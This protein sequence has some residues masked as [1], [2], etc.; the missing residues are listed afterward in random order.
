M[1]Q[2]AM[3]ADSE[4]ISWMREIR[5]HIHQ[6]PELSFQ[7][8][9]TA[10]YVAEKLRELE[11]PFRE[12]VA[13]TGILAWLG[14]EKLDSPCIG[15]RADMDALPILEK[16]GL[17]F[18]SSR[19][20]V[21]H[22]CG[23]DGHVAML[24]GAAALLKK[25]RIPGRIVFLFQPAEESEGGA[26]EMVADGALEGVDRIFAGH[27]DRHFEVGEIA[28]QPGLI[29]A[30]TDEFRIT[31]R[32]RGGHAAKPHETTDSIVVASLLVMSIQTLVSREVN[33]AFPSVV[34]VGKICGGSAPNVIAEEA[35]L[36]GTIRTTH[37]DI[38][39]KV[40]TGLKRM[41]LAMK[42]LYNAETS[43]ELIPGYPPVVN[44]PEAT[45]DARRA[46]LAVVG[47]DG[48][49]GLPYPSLGGE[50][51]SFYLQY[52]PGCMV[53]FGARRPDIV[54]AAA[55]SPRFDFDERALPVG[56]EYLAQVALEAMKAPAAA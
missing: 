55:H 9:D 30:F 44:E 2:P 27:I 43:M 33:P 50:D 24:L 47:P 21:M 4:L 41:V 25:C 49:K 3:K 7:E 19:E 39:E 1:N 37:P 5:R 20:G 17:P 34:T 48:V 11:I 45:E 52:I 46:A 53:R 14:D 29:C 32:G 42:D 18:A 12:E 26:R 13:R 38:R 40:I 28:V 31:I 54:S 10:R 8:F 36:V 51:F 15:L 6:N 16:T 56:A 35:V 22:A 23:H